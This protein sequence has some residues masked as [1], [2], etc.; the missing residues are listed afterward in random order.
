MLCYQ[1]MTFCDENKCADFKN[2]HRALTETVKAKAREENTPISR[3]FGKP[4]CF[5]KKK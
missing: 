3:Y 5:F 2:C 1:D 4:E